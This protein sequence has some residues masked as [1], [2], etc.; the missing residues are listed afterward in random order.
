MRTTKKLQDLTVDV[1][2]GLKNRRWDEERM[3]GWG[4]EK[5]KEERWEDTE[6][7]GRKQ[8]KPRTILETKKEDKRPSFDHLLQELLEI[9]GPRKN[10]QKDC[11]PKE[12]QT[13]LIKVQ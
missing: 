3:G 1:N 10:G 13:Y 8:T 2:R 12:S 5:R 4:N 7:R 11:N 6:M 9:T